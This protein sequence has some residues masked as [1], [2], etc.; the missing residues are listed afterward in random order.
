MWKNPTLDE[1]IICNVKKGLQILKTSDELNKLVA[2][3]KL[4]I[5]GAYYEIETGHVSLL[6]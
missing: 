4:K 3:K 5:V 2:E 6:D 1:G